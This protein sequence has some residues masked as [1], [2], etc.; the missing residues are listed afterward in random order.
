MKRF[1]GLVGIVLCA[2]MA[3]GAEVGDLIK[4]LKTGD[5]DARRA[6]AKALG[7]GGAESKAAVPALTQALKDK[8][9][10]VRRFSAQ[11]LGDIGPDAQ[12]A[13]PALTAALNDS[14]KEV[15]S[16]AARALGKMGSSGVETL[17]GILKD[18]SKDTTIRRQAIDSLS[19]LG[20]DA[21]SA[22][23][24]L[25]DLLKEN[26]GKGKKKMAPEDLRVDAATALGYLAK[27]GDKETID[28]LESLT[29]KKAKAPRGLKQAANAALKKIKRNK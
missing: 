28:T 5:N 6:A 19:G 9:L 8:D 26:T 22:V 27:A 25:T 21:R 23:P 18:D 29:G 14:R 20:A 13:V 11:A 3:Q 4:Q 2:T 7:E 16:A 24:V 15:R 1:L 12:S 17:I 10:F